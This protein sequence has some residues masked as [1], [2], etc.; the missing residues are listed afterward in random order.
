[1]ATSASPSS[2]VSSPAVR[3]GVAPLRAGQ[4]YSFVL[5]RLHSLTGIVPIGAFLLEHF[6]SNA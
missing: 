3:P 2:G 5:R 1:M 6:F 4:G